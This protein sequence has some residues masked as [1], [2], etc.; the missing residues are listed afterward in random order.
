L[1]FVMEILFAASCVFFF[2]KASC[3]F[4]VEVC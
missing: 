1:A 4:L 2:L 3:E